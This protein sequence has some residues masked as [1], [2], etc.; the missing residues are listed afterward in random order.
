MANAPMNRTLKS[1]ASTMRREMTK[2]ERKL[3]YTF[4]RT[5]EFRYRRQK[6]VPP[7]IVDF[8]CHRAKLAI[9]IDGSQHYSDYGKSYD[10]WR[11]GAIEKGGVKVLRFSN[12]DIHERFDGVKVLIDLVTRKRVGE[13]E[14]KEP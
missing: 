2:E 11:D 9:E 3:W 8:Y 14:R 7:F 6:V 10:Q 12:G 5:Y 13:L 4:L 1:R